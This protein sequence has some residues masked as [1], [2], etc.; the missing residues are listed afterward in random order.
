MKI[1]D[2]R[3]IYIHVYTYIYIQGVPKLKMP[4]QNAMK[5]EFS[6]IKIIVFRFLFQVVIFKI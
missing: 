4:N 6:K 5:R 3:H 2:T 1:A